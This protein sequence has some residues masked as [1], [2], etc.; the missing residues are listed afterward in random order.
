MQYKN[1]LKAFYVICIVSFALAKDDCEAIKKEITDYEFAFPI[2]NYLMN[3][4][5][6][7]TSL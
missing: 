4:A 5:E 1:I 6:E 7:V 2:Q 3:N